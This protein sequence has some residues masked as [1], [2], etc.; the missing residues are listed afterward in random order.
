MR[1]LILTA[2]VAA[3]LVGAAGAAQASEGGAPL[4]T[5]PHSW[6]GVF[7]RYDKAQLKRGFQVFH[8]VCSNCHT[9]RLVAYRNLSAVGLS[10][11]EIKTV[12]AERELPDAPNDEGVVV[13]RAGR[14]SDKYI[15][16]FPNEK[17]AAAANGGALP[18]DLSLMTKART[19]GPDYVYSLMLGYED[20]APEGHPIPE[21]K[22]Y[23][24]FFPGNAISMPPQVM[25]DLVTYAD[26][27]KATKEQLAA[28]IVAFLNWTAEPELDQRKGMGLY[29]MIFLGVLTALFYALK[30]QIWANV[31]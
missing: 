16:P 30:R 14:P 12:A 17:A 10:P 1:K 25:D 23:N 27:T 21:G 4:I 7:G 22:F 20:V 3:G 8:D 24:K 5:V 9:L 26:G 29:V 6:D 13:N 2:L 28:D 31:H 18:P 19:N 11:D 15:G